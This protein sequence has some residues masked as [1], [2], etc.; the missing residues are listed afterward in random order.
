MKK[1]ISITSLVVMVACATAKSAPY[2]IRWVQNDAAEE[3]AVYKV[4][5]VK[6]NTTNL[7]ATVPHIT[8]SIS[9]QTPAVELKGNQTI[10][11]TAVNPGG[12]G[13]ASTNLTFF[14]KP[15]KPTGLDKTP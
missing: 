14:G 7:L 3:V 5:Q 15:G 11:I 6:G 1:L 2:V 8:G 13:P 10:M 9:N 12:E 4:W